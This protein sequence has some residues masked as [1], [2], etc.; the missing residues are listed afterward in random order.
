M[1]SA[2]G[3]RAERV[4]VE[5][6]EVR[7]RWAALDLQQRQLVTRFEDSALCE[8]IRQALQ[9]L[10]ERQMMM[11]ELGVRMGD[12][13]DSN[14]PDDPFESSVLLKEG[15][16]FE[17]SVERNK[18]D[19]SVVLIDPKLGPVMSV[20]ESFS[21]RT[22][23]F[24]RLQAVMSDFLK[25]ASAVRFPMPKARWKE[26]WA[27]EPASVPAL[28][29][30]LVKLVEQALWAMALDPAFEPMT[31]P[32]LQQID[33]TVFVLEPWMKEFDEKV[34]KAARRKKKKAKQRLTL[35]PMVEEVVECEE[36]SDGEA[37]EADTSPDSP[38][39]NSGAE[40]GFAEAIRR[41]S[42]NS[43]DSSSSACTSMPQ[44]QSDEC[45]GMEKEAMEEEPWCTTFLKPLVQAT[46]GDITPDDL[47]HRFWQPLGDGL[48]VE[49]AD[50]AIDD[51]AFGTAT[52]NDYD[53][54]VTGES[55]FRPPLAQPTSS[56]V[57]HDWQPPQLVCYL[58]NQTS[59]LSK[60]RTE[61]SVSPKH[62]HSPRASAPTPSGTSVSTHTPS[63]PWHRGQWSRTTTQVGTPLSSGMV[64]AVVR[65]TFISVDVDSEDFGQD[66]GTPGTLKIRSSR[67]LSPSIFTGTD[68]PK[69]ASDQWSSSWYWHC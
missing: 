14:G 16:K 58:W 62:C 55:F 6:D 30:Q 11:H 38:K 37:D 7:R 47:E 44:T 46:F 10:F 64:S 66:A 19:P 27:V 36:P 31:E 28:E 17:W 65:N 42:S 69:P 35:A 48:V 32:A 57:H 15:F 45:D 12:A 39:V 5:E 34:A 2:K 67:S 50:S 59:Q 23:F 63:T 61:R 21:E 24:E 18:A 29:Q 60:G 41:N 22:D 40:A 4:R 43:S 54:Q 33:T 53:S 3:R 52:P 1:P 68:A 51:F 9:V 13:G 56:Q 25:P 49:D 20:K 26:L 8:R